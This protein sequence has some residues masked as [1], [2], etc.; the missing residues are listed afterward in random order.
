MDVRLEQFSNVPLRIV[1]TLLG[2]FMLV[3]LEQPPKAH[4]PIL[5]TPSGIVM[6]LRLEQ[7]MYLYIVFLSIAYTLNG[8]KVNM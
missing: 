5:V 6:E 8:R 4:S 3:R 1:V 2:M 7:S